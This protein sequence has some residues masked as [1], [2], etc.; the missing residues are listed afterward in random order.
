MSGA[1]WKPEHKQRQR[2]AIQ[3]WKPW[4]RSTG[5]TTPE[6]KSRAAAKPGAW[7]VDAQ[8]R[9]LM[10]RVHALAAEAAPSA[11]EAARVAGARGVAARLGAER[12][13]RDA[14]LQGL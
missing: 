5:P 9:D 3:H 4:E 12:R 7:P 11:Q 10:K 14:K 1:H 2:E 6:G 8:S 13:A